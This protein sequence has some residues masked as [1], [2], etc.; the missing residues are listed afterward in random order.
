MGYG[1]LNAGAA[2]CYLEGTCA[3]G[4]PINLTLDNQ[5]QTGQNPELSW[6][7]G[8]GPVVEYE[9]WRKPILAAGS[10]A[11]IATVSDLEYVDTDITI[12]TS[13]QYDDKYGYVVRAVGF[14][15]TSSNSNE[16]I[17]F[18]EV[19]Y[20]NGLNENENGSVPL[21]FGLESN[22]PNP[23]NPSTMLKFTLSEMSIVSLVVRD[24]SGRT[25][26]ILL[27]NDSVAAG[28]H[29]VKFDASNLPSGQ[30][31]YTISTPTQEATRSMMLIK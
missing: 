3:P 8:A 26:A 2:V 6:E 7:K 23:F 15:S 11:K 1:R 16:V 4:A 29:E 13:S 5:G 25:V 31:F 20:K 18:G 10:Y 21:S 30:Y 27:N 17:T 14:G 22:Y 19:S 9:V 12:G 24:I 28:I